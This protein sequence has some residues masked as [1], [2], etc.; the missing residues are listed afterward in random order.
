MWRVTHSAKGTSN[1]GISNLRGLDKIGGLGTLCQLRYKKISAAWNGLIKKFCVVL[2]CF[3]KV[4]SSHS[5][6]SKQCWKTFTTNSIVR[7]VSNPIDPPHH[8]LL[9]RKIAPCIRYLYYMYAT[10]VTHLSNSSKSKAWLYI[11][12]NK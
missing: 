2:V 10:I 3:V 4:W 11:G 9:F 7:K 5:N 1:F 8:V 6:I 12:N